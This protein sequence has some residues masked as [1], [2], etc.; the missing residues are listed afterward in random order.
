M[1]R[2]HAAEVSLDRPASM[3]CRR[4][5]HRRRLG[6]ELPELL[7]AAGA[8]DAQRELRSAQWLADSD[9]RPR[10]DGAGMVSG[11]HLS[12]RLDRRRAS[13]RDRILRSWTG[14]HDVE[15]EWLVVGV[16]VQRSDRQLRDY[17]RSRHLLAE[18]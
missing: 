10:R 1:G 5:L 9:S 18:A 8:T 17:A 4:D 15:A 7:Q 14:G 2:R 6:A 12:L 16:L 11:R 13:A 3:G